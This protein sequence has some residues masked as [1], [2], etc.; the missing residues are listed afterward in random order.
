MIPKRIRCNPMLKAGIVKNDI[1][2]KC[3]SCKIPRNKTVDMFVFKIGDNKFYLCKD[4]VESLF[5]K[6]L[7]AITYSNGRIKTKNEMSNIYRSRRLRSK[8]K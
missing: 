2:P 7:K 1:N 4:C 8:N 3:S 6:C 5:D